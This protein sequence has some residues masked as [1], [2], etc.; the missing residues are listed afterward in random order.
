MYQPVQSAFVT[1]ALGHDLPSRKARSFTVPATAWIA[2][3][4]TVR[5]GRSVS[6]VSGRRSEC[7]CRCSATKS[8]QKAGCLKELR[9]VH[10]DLAVPPPLLLLLT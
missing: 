9:V 1:V 5:A 3:V 6:L 10:T 4:T 7:A 2:G 8:T